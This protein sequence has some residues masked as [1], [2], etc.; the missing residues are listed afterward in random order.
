MDITS[1]S[2]SERI[3]HTAFQLFYRDG[4]RATGV[5]KIIAESG[6]AKLTFYRHYPSK[7]DLVRAF[8]ELRHTQWMAWFTDALGRHGGK[9]SALPRALAEWFAQPDFRG[10]AFINSVVEVEASVDGIGAIAQRHKLDMERAIATLL[11]AS[12]QR[13][14]LARAVAVALDGAIVRA[15]MG[16]VK[17]AC[18]SM[19]RLLTALERP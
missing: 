3:L 6:V 16:D 17:G 4:I 15:Q 5:D 9:L 10:C 1:L 2:A 18:D 8:L 12:R 19:A 7:D 11:P 14:A 13:P